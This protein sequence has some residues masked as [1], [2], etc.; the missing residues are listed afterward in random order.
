MDQLLNKLRA[1]FPNLTFTPGQNFFWSPETS[2]I[3]Y[4]TG[5]NGKKAQWSLLHETGHARLEHHSYQADFELLQLEVEAWEQARRL[6]Q[7]I[8]VQIDESHIQ[9]CLDTY[10]DWLYKRSIC[11]SC[12]TKCL[13]QDD[14]VHYRCFNC[15]TVWKVSAS[16][17]CRAYRRHAGVPQPATSL[18]I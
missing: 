12:G 7:E 17:F 9:D 14:H 11:P 13:Q 6:G 15:H 16:R 18:H 8:D 2:E 1:K 4:K 10:R 5:A 3:F